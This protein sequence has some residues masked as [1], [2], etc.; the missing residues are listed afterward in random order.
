MRRVIVSNI[1]SLDGYF[2]GPGKSRLFL[3]MD[4][5]FDADNLERLEAADVVL[6]GPRSFLLFSG[7]WPGIANAPHDPVDRAVDDVNRAISRRWSRVWKLVVADDFAVPADN[8][9]ADSTEVVGWA[10]AARRLGEVRSQGDG[11]IVVFGSRTSWNRL[12]ADDLVD[13]LHLTISPTVVGGGIPVFD[14]PRGTPVGF[15]LLGAQSLPGS[16]N[17]LVRYAA[18]PAIN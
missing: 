1:V 13:E 2:D 6:L 3:N 14:S 16:D 12:L 11:D 18:H 15:A 8:A 9:W 5:A 7:Y 10:D 17:V 4:A